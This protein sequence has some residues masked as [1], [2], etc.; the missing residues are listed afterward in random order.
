MH[1]RQALEDEESQALAFVR[2]SKL[3]G[4]RQQLFISISYQV[5]QEAVSWKPKV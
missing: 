2:L 5:L 3:A 1:S 4:H